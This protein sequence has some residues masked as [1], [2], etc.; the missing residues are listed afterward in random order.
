MLSLRWLTAVVGDVKNV[1]ES[2]HERSVDPRDPRWENVPESAR[3]RS[4]D[5]EDV[6]AELW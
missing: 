5:S 3:E 2:A 6:D 1:P 4:V